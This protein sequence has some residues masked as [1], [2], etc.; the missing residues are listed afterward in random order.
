VNLAQLRAE[1]E[2]AGAAYAEAL[3][4]LRAA[5]VRLAAIERTLENQN[6]APGSIRTWHHAR[7][8]LEEGLRSLQHHQFA[9]RII[10]SEWHDSAAAMSDAQINGFNP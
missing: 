6:V 9:A 8:Q 4:S 5:W 10:A 1:R 7:R 3:A 2:R